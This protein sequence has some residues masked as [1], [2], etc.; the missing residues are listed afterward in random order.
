M[1]LRELIQATITMQARNALADDPTSPLAILAVVVDRDGVQV[2]GAGRILM[3]S[4][5]ATQANIVAI[6]EDAIASVRRKWQGEPIE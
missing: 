1:T 6:L 5:E 4:E 3:E 2:C